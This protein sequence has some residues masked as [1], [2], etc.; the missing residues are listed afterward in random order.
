MKERERERER[1]AKKNFLGG[2]LLYEPVCS[3][4]THSHTQS[5][6]QP[7]FYLNITLNMLCTGKFDEIT[8]VLLGYLLKQF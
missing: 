1:D 4:L 7:F 5:R 6:V 2:K 3:S 8:N